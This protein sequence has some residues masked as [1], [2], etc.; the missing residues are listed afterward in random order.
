MANAHRVENLVLSLQ[1]FLRSVKVS[2]QGA[3]NITDLYTEI[4]LNR[5]DGL[6]LGFKF[7]RNSDVDVN[8]AP[9]DIWEG[10]G[11]YTGQPLDYIPQ[12]VEITSDEEEDNPTGT[13]ART[14][15]ITGL[16]TP[17]S[18][19][20]EHET[21]PVNGVA[22]ATSIGTW[23]RVNS[24]TVVTAG[25]TGSNIGTLTCVS[26]T[27]PTIVF[28]VATSTFNQ[29]TVGAYTIAAKTEML[30]KTLRMSIVRASGASGSATLSLRVR[31]PGGVFAS[32]GIFEVGTNDASE[33][34]PEGGLLLE[35]GS[36]IVFRVERVSDSNT[37]IEMFI[38]YLL[39]K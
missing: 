17:E 24:L 11:L 39:I 5:Q 20:Y 6:S 36:D 26:S 33:Y 9:E 1:A 34:T 3:L 18:T 14:V 25:S 16:K 8:S 10:S 28:A 19:E 15:M 37:V 35:A 7:G 38:E 31:K 2:K 22:T 12:T 13:G 29:S 23:W 32:Y 21:L 4:A 30:L 27:D